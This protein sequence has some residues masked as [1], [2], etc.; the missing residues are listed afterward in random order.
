MDRQESVLDARIDALEE[1]QQRHDSTLF[2]QGRELG[3]V[4]MVEIMWRTWV[5]ALC[6]LSAAAGSG[7]T[8]LFN[9][10]P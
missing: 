5:W 2:G 6:L 4:A 10:L 1:R 9:H 3:V 7:V 8:W